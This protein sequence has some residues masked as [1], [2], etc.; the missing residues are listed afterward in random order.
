VMVRLMI[1]RSRP[2][3]WRHTLVSTASR[4]ISYSSILLLF[5]ELTTLGSQIAGMLEL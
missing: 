1:G 5:Q 3:G 4:Y 2:H